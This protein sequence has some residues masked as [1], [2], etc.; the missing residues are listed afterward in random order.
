LLY[1]HWLSVIINIVFSSLPPSFEFTSLFAKILRLFFRGLPFAF[2][3]TYRS[4]SPF[5]FLRF[6]L[7]FLPF[8]GCLLRHTH[9]CCHTK[10]VALSVFIL[11]WFFIFFLQLHQKS[12]LW[13]SASPP[14]LVFSLHCLSLRILNSEF[15]TPCLFS[16]SISSPSMF[17]DYILRLLSTYSFH[18]IAYCHSY[19]L[20]IAL[21]LFFVF[22]I[23]Q[24]SFLRHVCFHGYIPIRHIARLF[25]LI[26]SLFTYFH[27]FAYLILLL[28][29]HFD[30]YCFIHIII[31]YY[32]AIFSILF[33]RLAQLARFSFR[34]YVGEVCCHTPLLA[35]HIS[36]RLSW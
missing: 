15:F 13:R 17:S 20:S 35:F 21:I 3:F 22:F 16:S 4:L 33:C 30:I 26:I 7:F 19:S 27:Y 18:Y 2:V 11:A 24:S 32:S 9:S 12:L 8:V 1:L 31:Y 5:I 28:L 14:S 10:T 34:H 23:F 25:A 6:S 29:F 36:C